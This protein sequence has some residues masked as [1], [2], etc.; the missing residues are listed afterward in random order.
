M[1]LTVSH[2]HYFGGDAP[3][4][5]RDAASWD[6]VRAQPGIFGMPE[7]A[8]AWARDSKLYGLA[9]RAQS[10]AAE[11]RALGATRICSYGVGVGYFERNLLEVAPQ[12]ELVCT[13]V[14]PR[15]LVALRSFFEGRATVVEHDFRVDAPLPCDVHLLHRV[16]TELS[17]EEWP[18][19]LARFREPVVLVQGGLLDVRSALA[20]ARTRLLHR[21]ATF[22]GWLRTRDSM[23]ALWSATHEDRRFD[24][25]GLPG[26]V[27]TPA[28]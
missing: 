2:R 25:A 11:L 20:E 6:A 10:V 22:S 4:A 26:Y 27:L 9:P 1:R 12:L 14:T 8:E 3:A 28:R 19:V 24:A 7:S 16:D 23:R 15:A 21:G 18:D 5:L 17:N 13:E